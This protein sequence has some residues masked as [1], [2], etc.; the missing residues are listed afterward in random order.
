MN[1]LFNEKLQYFLMSSIPS[2]KFPKWFV[3][4]TKEEFF[5]H[6]KNKISQ[7]TPLEAIRSDI[8]KHIKSLNLKNI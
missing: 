5:K 3:L 1:I 8:V 4:K 2:E 7:E 6:I